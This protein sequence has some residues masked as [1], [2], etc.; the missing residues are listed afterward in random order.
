MKSEKKSEKALSHKRLG[1]SKVARDLLS[2]VRARHLGGWQ[3]ST[4]SGR[5]PPEHNSPV[6]WAAQRL[7]PG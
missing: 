7:P 3:A 5:M 6:E 4:C 2:Q 1:L